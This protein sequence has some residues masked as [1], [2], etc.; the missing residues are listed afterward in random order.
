MAPVD[1]HL[2]FVSEALQYFAF[3]YQG[4]DLVCLARYKK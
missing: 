2:G 3:G 4:S 1:E